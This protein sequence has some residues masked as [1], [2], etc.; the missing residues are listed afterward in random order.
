MVP[1]AKPLV[2]TVGLV[3]VL[4][5]E[6]PLTD[7]SPAYLAILGALALLILVLAVRP[8]LRDTR[9]AGVCAGVVAVLLGGNHLV[10]GSGR[11]DLAV[12]AIVTAF[13]LLV[14]ANQL[15]LAP[16]SDNEPVV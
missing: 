6:W 3:T 16:W 12:G 14:L 4:L 13:G 10:A 5:S 15:G 1:H 11:P 8:N 2:A 7:E 9:A